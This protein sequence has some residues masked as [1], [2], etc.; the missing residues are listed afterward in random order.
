[1]LFRSTAAW[2]RE[3]VRSSEVP[4]VLD[5]DGLNAFE[6]RLG[7][8]ADTR[9]RL[10]LTPHVVE[11]ARLTG[12]EARQVE[13][14]RLRLP[15]R[16][17]ASTGHVVLLKGSPSVVAARGE[18]TVLGH[19]GNPGMAT[20]GAGDVLTG[21]ILGLLGQGVAPY[22]AAALGMLVHARA[23]DRAAE[24]LGVR[25]MLAGDIL[26]EEP[27]TLRELAARRMPALAVY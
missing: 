4:V 5:A 21:I 14:E 22:D 13:G 19:L 24:R 23:G 2:I 25:G 3:L 1:M 6:G 17:A 26:S 12:S 10:I 18:P 7:E 27:E 20:A 16:V 15:A 9:A 8:M 11:M